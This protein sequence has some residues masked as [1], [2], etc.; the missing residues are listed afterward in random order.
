MNDPFVALSV[1]AA[2]TRDL[3]LGTGIVQL[4]LHHPVE[5][6]HRVLSLVEVCGDRLILGVG[7]GSSETDFAAL[8]RDYSGRLDA[9]HR[10]LA[11]LRGLLRTGEWG[12]V[13]LNPVPGPPPP[14][15]YGTW[16]GDIERAAR[17]FDGWIA[18]ARF[19]G[20]GSLDTR[21]KRYRAAGGRRAIVTTV[22]VNPAATSANF[23]RACSGT[24][25]TGSMT[26]C[27]CSCPGPP[28]RSG[29]AHWPDQGGLHGTG[30]PRRRP[31][32]RGR[33]PRCRPHRRSPEGQD[34][35]V[36]RGRAPAMAEKA[37]T[38]RRG[39]ASKSQRDWRST[40]DA[41]VLSQLGKMQVG[42]V[43]TSDVKRPLRLLVLAGKHAAMRVVA[44]WIVA[45]LE[46]AEVENLREPAGSGRAIVETV[47][48]P[49]Q[50]AIRFGVRTA[51]RQVEAH[52]AT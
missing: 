29:C 40:M 28:I 4:P 37:E 42:A 47:T 31:P 9:L 16:G 30:E 7:A 13:S 44:G 12:E 27:S 41:Y 11:P 21:L 50:L 2:V 20:A 19:R 5:L 39:T 43:V 33:Q 18:S 14:I 17:E 23:A 34:D 3:E 10:D 35:L 24:R 1:A 46:W 51:A 25:I 22:I 8:Q 26:P 52:R 49:V 6:A 15:F 45:V 32:Y 48:R 38:W 36:R